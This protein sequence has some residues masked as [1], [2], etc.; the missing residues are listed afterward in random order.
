MTKLRS[1][2][3][4]VTRRQLSWRTPVEHHVLVDLVGD[5]DDVGAARQRC[6]R[7]QVVR[8][9]DRAGRIVRRV[10][11]DH[12]RARRDQGAHFVPVGPVV[13]GAQRRMH[14][15]AAGQLDRRHVAVVD[16]GEDDHL[17]AGPHAG[18]DRREDR[19][20]G[21]GGDGD[22]VIRVVAGAVERLDLLG[23]GLAQGRHA[24]HRRV[25]VV[26]RRPCGAP[27]ARAAAAAA[28]SRGSPAT[29]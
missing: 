20:G 19:L 5:D 29:G 8:R 4:G 22:L 23:D 26:R 13:G 3:P 14:R 28:R 7:G 10:D 12:A 2:R 16:R 24:G 9:P 15:P 6:Q 27:R 21:A 25:L 1:R 11:D 17:V 18:G